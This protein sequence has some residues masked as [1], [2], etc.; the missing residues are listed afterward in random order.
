MLNE[1]TSYSG[2]ENLSFRQMVLNYMR[3]VMDL[4][5]RVVSQENILDFANCYKRS[6]LGLSDVL[7]PFFDDEMIRAYGSVLE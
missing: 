5:L 6:V 4:N 1:D 3:R 2:D 7:L